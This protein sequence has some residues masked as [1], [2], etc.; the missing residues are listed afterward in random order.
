MSLSTARVLALVL[1]L[2][3]CSGCAALTG[4]D[5]AYRAEIETWHA[6][7]EAALAA[8]DGW[9][10][11][12]GLHPIAPGTQTLGSGPEAALRLID[13]APALLGTLELTAQ[14]ELVLEVAPGQS[15]RVDGEARSGRL[16]LATDATG[17]PTQLELGSLRLYAIAR[18]GEVFLR[19]KDRESPARRDFTGVERFPVD[20]RW[21]VEARL[22]ADSARSIAIPNVLGQVSEEPCPGRL[23]FTLAGKECSLWPIG[24]AG[25]ELFIIFADATSGAETY[26]AGRFL[27]APAPGADGRVT[28]DFNRAVNPPCTFSPYA[29]CP[30]PPA[31]NRLPI[32]VRAGEKTWGEGH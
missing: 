31:G 28:L 30:L 11:L 16:A 8:E 14:G 4:G 20:S 21:R 29:T 27:S 12:V 6:E 13:K 9:L 3:G 2:A 24:A 5:S 18:S 22:E 32:A 17:S 23:V 10:S 19:V 26:G 25:E 15:V 1:V 7:R